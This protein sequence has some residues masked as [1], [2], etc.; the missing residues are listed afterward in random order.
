MRITEL[1]APTTTR[2]FLQR[3]AW[4]RNKIQSEDPDYLTKLEQH[5]FSLAGPT[6]VSG[7]VFKK[8]GYPY[9]L[10]IFGFDNG[11]LNWYKFCAK[12]QSNPYLPK[13]KGG[14]LKLEKFIFGV[15]LEP[16]EFK[17]DEIQIAVYKELREVIRTGQQHIED[18]EYDY[19]VNDPQLFAAIKGIRALRGQGHTLD[20]HEGNIMWRGD[21]LVIIDPLV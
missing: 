20:I 12:N 17:S 8:A 16:L 6:G 3:V 1:N 18:G 9:V 13:I 7:A 14:L 15:R 2:K 4:D 10:K 5:G 19:L 21:Q 11:Y